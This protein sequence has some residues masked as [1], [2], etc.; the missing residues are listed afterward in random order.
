MIGRQVILED[1]I[2]VMGL[3]KREFV[4]LLGGGHSLGQMHPDRSGFMGQWCDCRHAACWLLATS[5]C[6]GV[7]NAVSITGVM[8]PVWPAADQQD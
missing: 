2:D 6:W 8:S 7:L 3:S 4:A 5:A 1:V